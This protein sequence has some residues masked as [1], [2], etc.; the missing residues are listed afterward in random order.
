MPRGR[1]TANG[2]ASGPPAAD[3]NHS[4]R[5]RLGRQVQNLAGVGRV[6]LAEQRGAIQ[7]RTNART[8]RHPQTFFPRG[9]RTGPQGAPVPNPPPR[10]RKPRGRQGPKGTHRL[11]PP[12]SEPPPARPARKQAKQ[13][14]PGPQRHRG[15]P[16]TRSPRGTHNDPPKP[17][18]SHEAQTPAAQP[19]YASYT[20]TKLTGKSPWDLWPFSYKSDTPTH[21]PV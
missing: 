21:P 14:D 13:G 19:P 16:R 9:K 10:G 18:R 20:K 3:L 11:Q 5:S 15:G 6:P 12:N 8:G 17:Q 4:S 2:N 7:I 1:Q